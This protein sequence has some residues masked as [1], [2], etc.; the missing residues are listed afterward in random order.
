[1][2]KL[3]PWNAKNYLA[4]GLIY[5]IQNDKVNMEKMLSKIESYA[6]STPE[7]ETARKELVL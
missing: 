3:D 2:V 7:A 5:K 4:L 6:G 1:M